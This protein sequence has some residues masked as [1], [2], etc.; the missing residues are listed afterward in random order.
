MAAVLTVLAAVHMTVVPL[1]T[2][3][4]TIIG[5]NQT[6]CEQVK[7]C[8]FCIDGGYAPNYSGV[9]FNSSEGQFC[10]SEP[11]GDCIGRYDICTAN[12]T[13]A[14]DP[15][16]CEYAGSP[17]CIPANDTNCPN[18]HGVV[19]CSPET[20]QCCYGGDFSFCCGADQACCVGPYPFGG[21]SCC[22]AGQT[23]HNSNGTC[24]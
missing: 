21:G 14:T 22:E 7:G 10:C 18:M 16:Q 11:Y 12:E 3:N 20:P 6:Q 2:D 17:I 19:P 4:C 23:C 15:N 9:C 8:S 13:C 5:N 24:S 1:P